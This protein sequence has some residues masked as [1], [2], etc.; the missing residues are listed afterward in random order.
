MLYACWKD[1]KQEHW[2]GADAT[3]IVRPP[4]S[5]D[6]CYLKSSVLHT[7]LLGYE[8]PETI[9]GFLQEKIHVLCTH[10]KAMLL[11][12]LRKSSKKQFG[13]DVVVHAKARD[14]DGSAIALIST[15]VPQPNPHGHKKAMLLEDLQKSSKKKFGLD[16][17]VHA[18]ARDD[19]GSGLM[20]AFSVQLGLVRN[21]HLHS[22]KE[23]PIG[24]LMEKRAAEL[25]ND[26]CI[27]LKE[28]LEK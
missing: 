14:D 9:M 17:V 18:K 28:T 4:R 3:A 1:Y 15:Q 13:L 2:G 5:E 7:W 10:K 21:P 24:A 25:L 19:D 20:K 12:D 27:N 11:E 26:L 8:F 6:L 22:T 23:A 16:V